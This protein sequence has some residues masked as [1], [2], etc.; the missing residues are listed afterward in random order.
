[1]NL[2]DW[3]I[4]LNPLNYKEELALLSTRNDEY[5]GNET[6][7]PSNEEFFNRLPMCNLSKP[8]SARVDK[9]ATTLIQGLFDTYIDDDTLVNSYV[10][11]GMSGL[12]VIQAELRDD[13]IYLRVVYRLGVDVP[14][15]GR[16]YMDCDEKIRQRAYLGYDK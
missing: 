2:I 15:L 8:Y 16:L 1:M 12:H 14:V 10:K 11:K 3:W 13:H 7:L 6:D 4:N 9:C 5:T